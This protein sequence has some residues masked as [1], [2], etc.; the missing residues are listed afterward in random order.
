MSHMEHNQDNLPA[1]SGRTRR[2]GGFTLVEILIAIVL[3]GILSA[4]VVVGVGNLTSKGTSAACTASLDAAKSASVV[5]YGSNNSAWPA[6]MLAMTQS[7]PPAL[8]LPSGVTL[9]TS[10]V[11][12]NAIGTVATGSGWTLTMTPSVS[13]AQPTFVCA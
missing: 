7:V 2:D 4:V 10:I 13:G 9:N 12:G 8:S 3:V 6:T 11:S 1:P 5:Y